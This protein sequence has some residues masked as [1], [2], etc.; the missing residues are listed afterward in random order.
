MIVM[1]QVNVRKK[2]PSQ[3][4]RAL[5]LIFNPQLHVNNCIIFISRQKSFYNIFYIFRRFII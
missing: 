1:M 5:L 3:L 2:R 4:T